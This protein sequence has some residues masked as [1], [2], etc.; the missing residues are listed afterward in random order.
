MTP[1][2]LYNSMGLTAKNARFR[3]WWIVA[4]RHAVRQVLYELGYGV[5]A[6]ATLEKEFFGVDTHHTTVMNSLA[7][8]HYGVLRELAEARRLAGLSVPKD[9]DTVA[10]API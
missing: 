1:H 7:Q 3:G 8:N 5:K 2:D 10:V 6:I 9:Y 4:K